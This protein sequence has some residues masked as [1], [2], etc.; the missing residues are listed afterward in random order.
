MA[1]GLVGF[2]LLPWYGL[3]SNFFTLSWLFDGYP[4]DGDVAPALF[5]VLQ[6]EKPWLAPLGVL[7]AAP[8]LLWGREKSDPLFAAA[9]DRDRRRGLRLSPGPGL[10]NRAQRLAVRMA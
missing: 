8:L 4:L 6:G 5:L 9:A 10:C 2:A 3:D 1:V 7:L